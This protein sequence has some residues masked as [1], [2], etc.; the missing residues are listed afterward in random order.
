MNREWT[1]FSTARSR[2]AP[3]AATLALAACATP[4]AKPTP[5]SSAVRASAAAG[6][7]LA[8]FYV[9][10]ADLKTAHDPAASAAAVA[11]IRRAAEQNLA[12]AQDR[13][14]L[15]YLKGRLLPQRTDLAL[16]WFRKAAERG[17]PAAGLQLG[18]LYAKGL[19]VPTD[20]AKAYYWYS[21]VARASPSDVHI[22]NL[23]EVRAEARRRAE[24]V[25]GFLTQAQREAIDARVAESRP[26]RSVPYNGRVQLPRDNE[27]RG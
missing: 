5:P 8:E 24:R 19:V 22:S 23:A 15:M 7:P 14:G 18:N 3:L 26:V 27:N 1:R 25:A 11:W 4:A 16:A 9:G 20:D 17:A 2:V 21:I 10:I 6:N 13:L 12:V